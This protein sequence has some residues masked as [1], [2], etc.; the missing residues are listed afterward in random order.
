[1]KRVIIALAIVVIAQTTDAQGRGRAVRAGIQKALA[2]LSYEG[3]V[4]T[5]FEGAGIDAS[6]AGR[7]L[8]GGGKTNAEGRG[9]SVYPGTQTVQAMLSYQGR[10]ITA[11]EGG[12]IYSSPGGL[13]LGGGGSTIAV[14]PG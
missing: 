11:F 13:D 10:V 8:G 12:G 6:P 3:R 14:Y 4:I 9:I 1:M 5:A 2:M 7:N